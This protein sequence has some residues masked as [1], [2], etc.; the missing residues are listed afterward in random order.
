MPMEH[1][2]YLAKLDYIASTK[3][4]LSPSTAPR[5]DDP[6]SRH[7][8]SYLSGGGGGGGGCSGKT[9][10]AIELF[11]QS[12]PLVFTPTHRLAKEMRARGVQAQTYHSFFRW[13]DHTEWTPE[14]MGQKFIPRV[15]IWDDVCTVPAPPWK[16]SSTGS[17][18]E[19]SRSSAVP[20][21]DSR[22]LSPEKCPTTGFARLH[23]NLPTTTKR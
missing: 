6:L 22:P 1:A 21:R 23:N 13:S 9:T 5:H 2:A 17:R 14:R 3:K 12:N 16:L 8:L 18:V 10:R 15:I 19:A 7:R 11:L 4:D 20:T